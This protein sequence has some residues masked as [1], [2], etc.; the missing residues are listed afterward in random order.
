MHHQ[1]E[2]GDIISVG[3]VLPALTFYNFLELCAKYLADGTKSSYWSQDRWEGHS[4]TKRDSLKETGRSISSMGVMIPRLSLIHRA[5]SK[6]ALM[7]YP[8]N[9]RMLCIHIHIRGCI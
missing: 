1:R 9:R 6:S 7:A 5:L 8:F 3:V 2:S 4:H